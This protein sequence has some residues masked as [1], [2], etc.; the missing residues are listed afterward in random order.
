[1]AEFLSNLDKSSQRQS[2]EE[3]ACPREKQEKPEGRAVE[4]QLRTVVQHNGKHYIFKLNTRL[5]EENLEKTE[6]QVNTYNT[7]NKAT[8]YGGGRRANT[9][10]LRHKK[11]SKPPPTNINEDREKAG[12]SANNA[13]GGG[14]LQS[15][16]RTVLSS[17]ASGNSF[18]MRDLKATIQP[19]EAALF[20]GKKETEAEAQCSQQAG[21][22]RTQPEQPVS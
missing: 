14:E 10:V 5:Q 1:M 3:A 18:L 12:H 21:E 9:N 13:K 15:N 8:K 16:I 20:A 17:K 19:R 7:G 4:G 11:K 2:C 6:P 22:S